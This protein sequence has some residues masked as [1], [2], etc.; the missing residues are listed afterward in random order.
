MVFSHY[1]AATQ[2]YYPG[3]S[4]ED[5]RIW[6]SDIQINI[7]DEI[8]AIVTDRA[9]REDI[10][11]SAV[12]TL[13]VDSLRPQAECKRVVAVTNTPRVDLNFTAAQPIVLSVIKLCIAYDLDLHNVICPDSL[14]LYQ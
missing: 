1:E 12:V 9:S 2:T 14:L 4:S 7:S 5:Q 6:H 3:F 13:A 10:Q 8:H 11:V